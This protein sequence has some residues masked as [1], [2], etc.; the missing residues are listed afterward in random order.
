MV[1]ISAFSAC[2]E[3]SRVCWATMG[4]SDSMTLA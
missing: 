1:V 4:A 2:R 3:S